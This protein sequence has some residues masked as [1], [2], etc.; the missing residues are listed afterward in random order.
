ME[1]QI[2]THAA[3]VKKQQQHKQYNKAQMAAA[4]PSYGAL[5]AP[6]KPKAAPPPAPVQEVPT[7][8]TIPPDVTV[9][10]LAQLLGK[11]PTAAYVKLPSSRII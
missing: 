8:V 3:I 1:Q 2:A 4:H 6:A 9:R 7:E 11:Q 10:Q 5:A